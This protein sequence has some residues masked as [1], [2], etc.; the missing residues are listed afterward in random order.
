[1]NV[2]CMVKIKLEDAYLPIMKRIST[3]KKYAEKVELII[4]HF[5]LYICMIENI[6]VQHKF[7]PKN[8]IL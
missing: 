2:I 3:L 6:Y 5:T 1:M 7:L 8:K 4:C